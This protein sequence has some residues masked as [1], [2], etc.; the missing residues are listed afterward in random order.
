MVSW[1][2]YEVSSVV[3]VIGPVGGV[4]CGIGYGT[5]MR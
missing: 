5:G 1:D 4:I 2:R 3:L